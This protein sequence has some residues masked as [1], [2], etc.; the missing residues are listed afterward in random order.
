MEFVTVPLKLKNMVNFNSSCRQIIVCCL[1][2]CFCLSG[3]TLAQSATVKEYQKVFT[4]YPY[5][6]PSPIPVLSSLYPY[7]RY[8][9][10]TDKPVQ[11]EWKVVELENDYIK[12]M[13]LPEIGG[14]IWTA[15]EKSTGLPFI[16][17]NHAVKFRDI[18]MRGPYTSGGLELNYGMIGHTPNCAT[19]VDYVIQNNPDGS[20]SCIVGVL[21]LLTRTNWRLEIRLPKD[22]AYFT[23]RTFWYNS[24]PIEQPYYHWLNGGY[25]AGG[26]L[27]FIFPGTKYIGHGGEYADWPVNKT[28]GKKISFYESNNFGGYKSYHV[29]GKLTNFSG[30]YWHDDKFGMV[31]YGSYDDKAGKKIWIWGLS[32]Q[33][34]IW[35]KFLTD[36]DGQYVEMQSG[37]LFNQNATTATFTPFKHLNFAPYAT[38]IWTEYFYPVLRTR[39]YV[40]ANEFGALNIKNEGGMLKIYFSPVQAIDD[41]LEVTEG[42]KVI[43]TRKLKLDPLKTFGD[44]LKFDGNSQNLTVTLGGNKLVYHSDPESGVLSRPVEAPTDFDWNTAYGLFVQGKEYMDQKMYPQAEEKLKAS[45]QKDHNYFPAMLKMAEL[46]Y[47]NMLYPQALEMATKALAIDTHDGA[48][49]YYYGLVNAR[50]GKITDAID[51]FSLA[52]LSTEYRSA[53]YTELSRIYL[54]EKNFGKALGF[55]TRAID[56]N[57]YNI[58]A[59]QLQAVIFR[60]MKDYAGEADVLKNI[61]SFDPLNHFSMF[62]KYL[63]TPDEANKKHFTGLI[64]NELPQETFI[65]LAIWY[66]NSG[67]VEEAEKV[68]SLSPP[69]AETIFWL[70]FLQHRKVNISEINP[71]FSFPFRSETGAVLEQLLKEQQ[72]WL[73]KYSLALIYKD[74]NRNEESVSLLLSCGDTPDFAPFYVCRAEIIA[75]KNISQCESDLKK[76]VS[77]D[78]EW[79]YQLRLANF[80]MNH[81]QYDKALSIAE[82]FYKKHPDNFVIGSLYAKALLLSKKY[83]EADALLTKIN[84]IPTEGATEGHELYR[85]AKLMQAAEMM[86]KKNYKASLKFISEARLWPENLGVGKPYDED[87]DYRL[88]DWMTYSC[89]NKMKKTAE[90]NVILENIVK[91]EPKVEN[92][93]RNFLPA[94][95]LITAWAYEALNRKSEGSQFIDR[96]L[97]Y[98]PD[99]RLILW[100]KAVYE[101]DSSFILAENEKDANARIIEQLLKAGI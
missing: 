39:G 7:F 62:E 18:A 92:T 94:N 63:M 22:K 86:K 90:A 78:N 45:L 59:L 72:D 91:F 5:S 76:A 25:K 23:T 83:P 36:T 33:G 74:R 82:P 69:N 49:N 11:K 2:S 53:A 81:Q 1:L 56:Y 96:Q 38:D 17:Y 57:R 3:N 87:I 89:Y 67:C 37:R 51:G 93:V 98:F 21:D 54:L 73:L 35:E 6:D 16:Y 12:V 79:R 84:I 66:Y 80:Y 48:A 31:R 85:E 52:T 30:G 70:S 46:C 8:E 24:T 47:R 34:M 14:K 75:G 60:S 10:Y 55:A 58:E 71:A 97:K 68:F 32:G 95:S 65:E 41:Q 99:Y 13:I 43:Y 61:L 29:F 19:P 64:R 42:Q 27:E 88:E 15:I 9:G 4:T 77:I 28:N 44:S 26:N 50:L 20:V 40:E 100:S 101:K